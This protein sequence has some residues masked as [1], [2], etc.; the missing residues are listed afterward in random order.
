MRCQLGQSCIR[1]SLAQCEGRIIVV[2]AH[3]P[4]NCGP[5][6]GGVPV[7]NLK[8]AGVM[9]MANGMPDVYCMSRSNQSEAGTL[10]SHAKSQICCLILMPAR[11]YGSS[12][13]N[14]AKPRSCKG[15]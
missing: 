13:T 2:A 6:L 1:C 14:R 8:L 12:N 4:S 3:I 9:A 11:R 15:A 10:P 7:G 5:G